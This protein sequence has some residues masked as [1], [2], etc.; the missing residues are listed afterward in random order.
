MH[1]QVTVCAVVHNAGPR[2][3]EEVVQ[4]Y[5]QPQPDVAGASVPA[6]LL[7]GFERT[8]VGAA[9]SSHTVAPQSKQ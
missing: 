5:G 6:K 4:V 9:T 7:L 1:N 2:P 8:E 3:T